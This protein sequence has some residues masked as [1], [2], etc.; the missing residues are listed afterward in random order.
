MKLFSKLGSILIA[1]II[2]LTACDKVEGLPFFAQVPSSGASALTSSSATLAALPADSSKVGLTFTWT[3]PAYTVDSATIKYIIEIDSSSRNFSKAVTRTFSGAIRTTYT[4]KELNDIFFGLGFTFNVAYDIDVRITSSHANNNEVLRSNTV[5]IRVTPY[6]VP[7]RVALPTSSRLFIVG[8]GTDFDWANSSTVNAAEEFARL[9]ETTWAGVFNLKAG[10]EYLIL[11]VKGDWSNKFA[12]S[13]TGN[14]AQRTGGSFGFN[15]N[16][17]FPCPTT[18]GSYRVTI[19]FQAGTYSVVPYTGPTLPTNLFLVGDATPAGWA[20]PATGVA[21][22]RLTR[23]NSVVW[24]MPSIALTAG[25]YLV[26]PVAGSWTNKYA[27]ANKGLAGLSAGGDF[28]YNS[29]DNFPG[30]AAGNYRV[31]LNFATGRFTTTRL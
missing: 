5:K 27:V 30:P 4:N 10:G 28:G 1:S 3:K 22:Q 20:N 14:A 26:L 8:G 29:N 13:S 31:E 17:N 25:E 16:D 15:S 7:P 18:A 19:D 23:L 6:K 21:V 9:N 24:Q 12:I 2:L 11:P